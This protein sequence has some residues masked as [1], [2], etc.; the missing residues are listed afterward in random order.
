M[1]NNDNDLLKQRERLSKVFK[2]LKQ[3]GYSQK[4]IVDEINDESI[5]ET[6]LSCYKSGKIKYIPNLF[7]ESLHDIFNI[8]P[9]YIRLKSDVML[10]VLGE[11]YHYF[12]SLVESWHVREIEINDEKGNAYEVPKIEMKL[13]RNFFDFLFEVNKLRFVDEEGVASF[14]D[15]IDIIKQLYTDE[16]R[17]EDFVLIPKEKFEKLSCYE[18]EKIKKLNEVIALFNDYDD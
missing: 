11:K 15:N 16:E 18:S 7:L 10:D 5:D 14:K 3:N 8:N 12:E 17:I 13:D 2:Y 1:N 4:N 9:N 6:T